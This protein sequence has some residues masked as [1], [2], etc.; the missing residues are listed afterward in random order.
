MIDRVLEKEP[1]RKIRTA[2]EVTANEFF[3]AGHFPGEP[4]VPGVMTL[5]GMIQSALILL[6]E[7]Q[8]RGRIAAA[9][10]KVGRLKF[11]KPVVPGDRLEFQVQLVSGENQIYLF[12][13]KALVEEA[14][15][16]EAD[17]TIKTSIREAGFG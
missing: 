17:F 11:K 16:A 9:L 7:L 5:E 13:G 12:K 2:K 15:A 14:A 8:S 4:I 10:T 1:G 3:L 6:D